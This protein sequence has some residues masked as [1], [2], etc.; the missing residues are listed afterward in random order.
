MQIMKIDKDLDYYKDLFVK[1]YQPTL[2]L[3]GHFF[4]DANQAALD[5]LHLSSVE[6]LTLLHPAQ[7]SPSYQPDG[8]LS[9]VKADEMFK[10]LDD[11]TI[12]FNR[13]EWLHERLD[14]STFLVE[15]T[16]KIIIVKDKEML[17]VTWKP[18]D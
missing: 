5:M 10:T 12:D 14:G 13:F 16:L 18:I 4:V 11:K 17:Y 15:V 9:Q 8:K 1:A 7:I 6:E 3:D 2:L